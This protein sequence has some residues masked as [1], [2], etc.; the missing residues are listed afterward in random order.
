MKRNGKVNESSWEHMRSAGLRTDQHGA[1][2][3]HGVSGSPCL[4]GVDGVRG[5]QALC[6][7]RMGLLVAT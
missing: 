6:K 5:G 1:G 3:H 7:P 4:G 2:V